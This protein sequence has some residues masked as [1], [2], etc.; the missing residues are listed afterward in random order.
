MHHIVR[1]GDTLHKIARR[2]GRSI[3]VIIRLNPHI[4]HRPHRIHPG[5]RIRVR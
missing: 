1:R 4:A 3:I 2:H 5:E